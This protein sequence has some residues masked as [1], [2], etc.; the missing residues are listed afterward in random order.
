MTPS[1]HDYRRGRTI[2]LNELKIENK[3]IYEKCT[4]SFI[5]LKIHR[6]R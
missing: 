6:I 3:E 5:S 2:N 1:D 4:D